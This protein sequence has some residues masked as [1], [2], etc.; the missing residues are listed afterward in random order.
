MLT[1]HYYGYERMMEIRKSRKGKQLTAAWREYQ[2]E[3]LRLQEENAAKLFM[4]KIREKLA[5]IEGQQ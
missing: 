5:S 2:S 4:S 3:H 1:K